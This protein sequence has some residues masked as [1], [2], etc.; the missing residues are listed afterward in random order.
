MPRQTH[1]GYLTAYPPVD[2]VADLSSCYY[3]Y[4][5]FQN[6]ALRAGHSTP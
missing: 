6:R 4:P 1:G 2:L 3:A 5:D